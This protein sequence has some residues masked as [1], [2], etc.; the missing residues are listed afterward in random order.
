MDVNAEQ[1][2]TRLKWLGWGNERATARGSVRTL[3]CDPTCMNGRL[4][5]S[6]G[7]VV[8]SAPRRCGGRR[9]YTRAS[10]T[11][12]DPDTGKTRAPAIYL[13]TPPC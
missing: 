4:G 12:D 8:L 7:E 9:F 5:Y 10:M 2:L 6:R 1:E 3:I 11:Y 13:R